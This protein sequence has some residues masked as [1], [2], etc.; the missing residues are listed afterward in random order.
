MKYKGLSELNRNQISENP[1][2]ETKITNTIY[3]IVRTR[4]RVQKVMGAFNT[5]SSTFYQNCGV[6]ERAHG[7]TMLNLTVG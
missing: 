6:R 4:D 2:I 1:K 3:Y 7:E 5:K